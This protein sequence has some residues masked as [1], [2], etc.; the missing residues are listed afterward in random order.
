MLSINDA[1]LVALF[2]SLA[3]AG[4][5]ISLLD[6]YFLDLLFIDFSCLLI[7]TG[8]MGVSEPVQCQFLTRS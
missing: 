3:I 8:S 1:L 2:P 4:K 6:L 7:C 5:T